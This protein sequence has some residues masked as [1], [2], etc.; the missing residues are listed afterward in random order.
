MSLFSLRLIPIRVLNGNF[1]VG[2]AG[3]GRLF[4]LPLYSPEWQPAERLWPLANE[5]IV[6]RR[7]ETLDELQE[8]QVP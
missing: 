3:L 8:V 7:F 4:F 5:V 1:E 2:K 6:N